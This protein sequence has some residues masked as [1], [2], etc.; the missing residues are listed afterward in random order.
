MGGRHQ[1]A[2]GAD[3]PG[4]NG[5]D[6]PMVEIPRANRQMATHFVTEAL[7]PTATVAQIN[8]EV[9]MVLMADAMGRAIHV[10]R[11][12]G[13]PLDIPRCVRVNQYGQIEEVPYAYDDER[14]VEGYNCNCEQIALVIVN[15]I[16]AM[17]QVE[18][19]K[20]TPVVE[21]V[22]RDN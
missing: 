9:S 21:D 17:D 4:T 11:G 2:E 3:S 1:P 12:P 8:H 16:A 10:I 15:M 5:E 18:Q 19:V 20:S 22:G 7:G 6:P 14:G 13:Q